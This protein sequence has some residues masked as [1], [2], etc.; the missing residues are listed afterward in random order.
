MVAVEVPLRDDYAPEVG[1][2]VPWLAELIGACPRFEL[3][4]DAL[5]VGYAIAGTLHAVVAKVFAEGPGV[6][7]RPVV[8]C[9]AVAVFLASMSLE[10]FGK[11]LLGFCLRGVPAV[12][13]FDGHEVVGTYVGGEH[14]HAVAWLRYVVEACIVHDAGSCA[15]HLVGEGLAA[16]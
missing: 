10:E 3:G 4:H 14:G 2:I 1:G 6:D 11:R 8:L 5:E 7:S 9:L 15:S 12:A 13:P 16:Q